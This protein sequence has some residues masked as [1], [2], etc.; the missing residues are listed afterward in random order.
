MTIGILCVYDSLSSCPLS[1]D[2]AV[3]LPELEA[4]C[5]EKRDR[6]SVVHLHKSLQGQFRQ[7]VKEEMCCV[8]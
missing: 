6:E 2:I 7:R 8:L 5:P 1:W 3:G 4:S